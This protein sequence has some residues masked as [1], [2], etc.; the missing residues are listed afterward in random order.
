[1][2]L[3]MT[4]TTMDPLLVTSWANFG[5]FEISKFQ[6]SFFPYFGPKTDFGPTV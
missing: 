1:M 2:C 3:E 6:S 4:K 5:I